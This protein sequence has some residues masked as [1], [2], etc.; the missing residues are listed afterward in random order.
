MWT[1]VQPAVGRAAEVDVLVQALGEARVGQGAAIFLAGEAGVGKTGTVLEVAGV[2]AREGMAVLRGR[3]SSIGPHV[4][5]RPISEALLALSRQRSLPDDDALHPYRRVLGHLVPDWREDGTPEQASPVLLAEALLRLA[6]ALGSGRGCL[7]LLEDL[8]DVDVETLAVV[9][10]LTDNVAGQPV[11]LLATVRT[12]PSA[13]LAVAEAATRRG[14]GTLHTLSRLDRAEIARVAARRLDVPVSG[15]PEAVVDEL[16]ARSA[17]LWLVV[18]ELLPAMIDDGRLIRVADGWTLVGGRRPTLPAS[19]VRH[20]ATRIEQLGPAGRP[21]LATAAVLGQRFPVPVLRRAVDLDEDTLLGTLRAAVAANLIAA[22]E[23]NPDRYA[24]R[25]PLATEA[26]LHQLIRAEHAA[27][28]ARV[29]DAVEALHPGLPGHWCVFTAELRSRAGAPLAAARLFTEASRRTQAEGGPLGVVVELLERA[30]ELTARQPEVVL[31][32]D[33]LDELLPALGETG[34]FDDALRRA[35]TVDGLARDGLDPVRV[36]TLHARL[37]RVACLAGEIRAA[38]AYL[39]EARAAGGPL[40]AAAVA[41]RIDAVA[42]LVA[43][44][45]PGQ[46]RV[47]ATRLARRALAAAE[48]EAV[49]DVAFDAWQALGLA[50]RRSDLTESRAAFDRARLVAE[51]HRLAVARVYALARIAGDEWLADGE[52]TG[53]ERAGQEAERQGLVVVSQTVQANLA[54]HAALDGRFAEATER[55]DECLRTSSRLGLSVVTRYLL[56]TRAV[57]HAHRGRRRQMEEALGEFRRWGGEE[58]PDRSITLGLARAYCALLEEDRELAWAEL[59]QARSVDI[60]LFS[61]YHLAGG[62]GL[63]LLLEVLDGVAGWPEYRSVTATAASRM[64]WNRQFVLLARAVLLGRDGRAAEARAALGESRQAASRYGMARHLGLR[65]VAEEAHQHGW[66]GG[67]VG[68]R[69]AEEYFHR[70][71]APAVAS[72]CRA[73]LRQIGAPVRQRRAGTD[74][75]PRVLRTRGVTLRE[76]EVFELLESR[77]TNKAIAGRLHISPRTVEKHIASLMM[78]TGRADRTALSKYAVEVSAD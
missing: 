34:R 8:Q 27:I 15:V 39:D 43:L 75:V 58:T 63:A 21:V 59:V 25:H 17:G 14:A 12:E 65:L 3:G 7:L 44:S 61:A 54:L 68:L 22:D 76:Y 36:A 49:P 5:Y 74:R 11:L 18:E 32:A 38:E 46:H 31:W 1:H 53:L 28:C 70:A 73:L 72:A 48:A 42:A 62:H 41:A 52:T 66:G 16:V 24:F 37:A 29:A 40:P 45:R 56:A 13:A 35:E 64:R 57:L 55:V 20:L 9:D 2:A 10:Y 51:R 67:E 78:K 69:E 71:G 6:A 4:P 77:L 60:D 19:L 50:A 30:D 47:A 23:T 33:V 26:L